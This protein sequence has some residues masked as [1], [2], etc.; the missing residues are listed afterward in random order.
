MLKSAQSVRS[1]TALAVEYCTVTRMRRYSSRA[2]PKLL[3]LSYFWPTL[4]DPAVQ[5]TSMFRDTR[6]ALYKY[7]VS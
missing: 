3:V 6:S 2:G 4:V 7:V 5:P 1:S